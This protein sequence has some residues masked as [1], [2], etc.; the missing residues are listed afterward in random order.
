MP[1][2]ARI[3]PWPTPASCA[4]E[5]QAMSVKDRSAGLPPVAKVAVPAVSFGQLEE[6]VDLIRAAFPGAKINL[7]GLTVY[8]S[9]EET[10]A[11]LKGHEAAIVSFEPINDRVLSELPELR[12]VSKLGVGLNKIDPHAMRRHGVRLGWRPGVNKTAVAE[13]ALTMAMMALRHVLPCNLAMRAAERPLQRLGRQLSGRVVGVH[14]TG[15]IGGELIRLLQPFGCEILGN[16]IRDCSDLYAAY[17]V[18]KVDLDELLSRSEILS[19]H[20]PVTDLTRRLYSAETLDRLRPE[21]V[22][23]NTARGEIIDEAALRDRLKDGKLFAAAIDAFE[24]EPP[25]DDELLNLP[26]FIATPHIGA[27]SHEARRAMGSTA[28]QGLTDNFIPEPG[29]YPFEDR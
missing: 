8:R 18:R 15:Q 17:G 12:V 5:T 1:R 25:E 3:P 10:I 23:I 4:A 11:Y 24:I 19:I 29:V 26:N 7:E 20:L 28:I 14:G 6:N 2:R 13:L 21:C 27:A 16:D 9:E 22:L